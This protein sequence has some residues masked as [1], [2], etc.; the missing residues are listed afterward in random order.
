MFNIPIFLVSNSFYS[1]VHLFFS[2]PSLGSKSI[3]V[4]SYISVRHNHPI[5]RET[6]KTKQKKIQNINV[7]V[8]LLT[9]KLN[10]CFVCVR[11]SHFYDD[12]LLLWFV[13]MFSLLL[14]LLLFGIIYVFSAEANY[15]FRIMNQD[16]YKPWA[17]KNIMPMAIKDV[18]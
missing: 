5:Q 6:H 14:F 15:M 2:S 1:R 16:M 13:W 4:V 7:I 12:I 17:Y 9:L 11:E 10:R 8:R 18:I 3:S